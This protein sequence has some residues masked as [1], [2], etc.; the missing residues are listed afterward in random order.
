[1]AAI[2]GTPP[3]MRRDV[4]GERYTR[5]QFEGCYGGDA[6]ACWD[7]AVPDG[8]EWVAIFHCNHL[9]E[10][11]CVDKQLLGGPMSSERALIR[12]GRG[13]ADGTALVLFNFKTK[14][15]LAP[16]RAAGA[17]GRNLD[18][19]AWKGR[20]PWQVRTSRHAGPGGAWPA[21]HWPAGGLAG[22]LCQPGWI[23]SHKLPPAWFPRAELLRA[24]P[25]AP[26]APKTLPRA[27]ARA[28]PP[29]PIAPR[30]LPRAPARAEPPAP[31][32]P[33]T[34]PRRKPP[35]PARSPDNLSDLERDVFSD[36]V[37]PQDGVEPLSL[38][39]QAEMA[40]LTT[41]QRQAVQQVV[42][43]AGGRTERALQ[44]CRDADFDVNRAVNFAFAE[45]AGFAPE[46]APAPLSAMDEM[47]T[48]ARTKR[49]QADAA[50]PCCGDTNPSDRGP[51]AGPPPSD[52]AVAMSEAVTW[53][54]QELLVSEARSPTHQEA[55][56]PD[57]QEKHEGFCDEC[58]MWDKGS[59]DDI[60]GGWYCQKCW[61]AMESRAG[62]QPDI[63][64]MKLSSAPVVDQAE[65]RLLAV[66]RVF[67]V[68]YQQHIMTEN[69]QGQ[70][71][72]RD[73]IDAAKLEAPHICILSGKAEKIGLIMDGQRNEEFY[74]NEGVSQI[75]KRLA[76][77]EVQAASTAD[78]P[79]AAK[80]RDFV[81]HKVI[82]EKFKKMLLEGPEGASAA[83]GKGK[84]PMQDKQQGKQ[85][86][87]HRPGKVTAGSVGGGSFAALGDL[88]GSST[89]DS[90]DDAEQ[91]LAGGQGGTCMRRSLLSTLP[92]G[93][94]EQEAQKSA[95]KLMSSY[96]F[97]DLAEDTLGSENKVMCAEAW[98][99]AGDRPDPMIPHN[100]SAWPNVRVA[101]GLLIERWWGVE[102]R[103]PV[104]EASMDRLLR[105]CRDAAQ[106]LEKEAKRNA[107]LLIAGWEDDDSGVEQH[108]SYRPNESGEDMVNLSH[109]KVPVTLSAGRMDMLRS[110]LCEHSAQHEQQFRTRVY[111]CLLR[112]ETLAKFDQGTQG[113]LPERVFDVLSDSFGVTH[114]C[115]A[116]PLNVTMRSFNSVFPDVD[117]FFGSQGSFFD[118]WPDTGAFEANPPFDEGSV[119]AMFQHINAVL[120]KA[121]EDKGRDEEQLP[122][123]YVTVTP[124]VPQDGQCR[125]EDRFMLHQLRLPARTH[126]Y[127]MGM[128]HRKADEWQ[129]P[130]ETCVCFVGNRAAARQWAVTEDKLRQLQAAWAPKSLLGLQ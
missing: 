39:G 119:A 102:R 10:K 109:G 96:F 41:Y 45:E 69:E 5:R 70:Y 64:Y 114:E 103:D 106:S 6:E 93:R 85:Q 97:R 49:H 90:D 28:E 108:Q 95:A 83:T 66:L 22:Q 92:R 80:R 112:Y 79:H 98:R 71:I 110:L 20:F 43:I 12:P 76:T 124:F 36:A 19:S 54:Q 56:A 3:E 89:S 34:P 107:N 74:F 33:R 123:L 63:V 46:P 27:P 78:S 105:W 127:T 67:G 51:Q 94:A 2:A 18:S 88:S 91:H 25:A 7:S 104:V 62:A 11:E 1:M 81:V 118:F 47:M 126:V 73:E 50:R 4:D 17:P 129:C 32:S 48:V 16:L 117:K 61:A 38:E 128:R 121:E 84:A 15:V 113:S 44:L 68:R 116:S 30:T 77:R 23:S 58:R 24:E 125:P 57:E 86:Q 42:V 130:S 52:S 65:T 120:L 75:C 8:H 53:Q 115:F 40:S 72:I 59:T 111:N 14:Q 60:D 37:A 9:T 29:A 26:I 21:Q 35:S 13:I 82:I 99:R 122:L 87:K 100:E 55:L 31:I 101:F